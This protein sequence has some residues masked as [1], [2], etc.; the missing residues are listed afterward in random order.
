[1]H[2]A[3]PND[4]TPPRRKLLKVVAGLLGAAIT[5]VLAVPAAIMLG[6]VSRRSG[7]DK[8]L[9]GQDVADWADVPEGRP[10]RVPVRAARLRDA[11]LAFT[12]VTVGAVWLIRRDGEVHALSTVCPHAGCAVQWN[13]SAELFECPCHASTFAPL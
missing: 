1:M 13:G 10:V 6:S 4:D 11:W 12:N 7:D 5:G 3:S 8:K 9:P 2:I